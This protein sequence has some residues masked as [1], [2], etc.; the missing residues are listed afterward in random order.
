[1]H[2]ERPSVGCTAS[3]SLYAL[4]Q[5]Q[6]GKKRFAYSPF[7]LD[8]VGSLIFVLP[9]APDVVLSVPSVPAPVGTNNY[10]V[11]IE[12]SLIITNNFVKIP[13]LFICHYYL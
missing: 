3:V 10:M 13:L 2:D 11:S 8:R 1:M 6:K 4:K 9:S 7:L 12:V 5:K